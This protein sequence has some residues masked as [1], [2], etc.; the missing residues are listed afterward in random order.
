MGPDNCS[1]DEATRM[2]ESILNMYRENLITKEDAVYAV[3][4]IPY[5]SEILSAE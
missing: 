4:K 1:R 3:K 2:V 5:Y